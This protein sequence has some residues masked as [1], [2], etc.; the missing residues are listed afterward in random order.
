[1]APNAASV[2]IA[3]PPSP[4]I[5]NGSRPA[6]SSRRAI[7]LARRPP[8][9]PRARRAVAAQAAAVAPS[10]SI[11]RAGLAQRFINHD[12]HRVGEIE[13]PDARLED[14]YPIRTV[15]SFKHEIAAQAG[16]LAAKEKKIAARIVRIE[17]GR[18]S[19]SRK[20]FRL[21]HF[22]CR[23]IAMHRG[24]LLPSFIRAQIHQRPVVEA[25]ALEIAILE[26]ESE[27]THQ[28]EPGL[29]RGGQTGDRSCVLRNLGANQDDVQIRLGQMHQ[30]P[31]AGALARGY[32]YPLRLTKKRPAPSD[33]KW[34]LR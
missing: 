17:I 28:V 18:V 24:E 31:G 25:G 15:N 34:S 20:K 14:W 26:R 2:C 22:R 10:R 21:F 5:S 23:R 3:T 4:T 30:L 13:A 7:I 19:V 27:R 6:N 1:M 8:T 29:G 9:P 12:R 32:R 33:S 11:E 16:R